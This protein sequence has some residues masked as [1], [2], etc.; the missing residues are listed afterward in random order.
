M[1]WKAFLVAW[2][3]GTIGVTLGRWFWGW[4]ARRVSAKRRQQDETHTH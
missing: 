3:F 1:T 4:R 2:V